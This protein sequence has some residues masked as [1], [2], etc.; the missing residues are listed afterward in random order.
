MKEKDKSATCLFFDVAVI[1]EPL[2]GVGEGFASRGLWEAEFAD[3]FGWVEEHFVGG[4]ADAGEGGLGRLAGEFGFGFV[5]VGGNEREGVGDAEFWGGNAGQFREDFEGFVHG[6]IAL[7]IA[8]YV[9]FAD[10]PFLG[11]EDVADG[12]IADVDPVEA[13]VE[14]GGH[15]AVEE[16]DDDAAGGGGFDVA[17]ADGS[18][19]IDDDDGGALGGEFAGN[20]FGAPLGELVVVAH[21]GFGNGSRFV[22]GC[23]LAVDF[24]GQTDAADGAGV[25]D[26]GTAGFGGG[27]DDVAGAVDVGGI[28]GS[29][30]AE[31]EMIAGGDVEAPVAAAHGEGVGRTV[32]DIAI[33]PFEVDALEA[34]KVAVGA[35]ESLHMVSSSD[36]F[37]DKIGTDEAGSACDEAVHISFNITKDSPNIFWE[38]TLNAVGLMEGIKICSQM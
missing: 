33:D 26:S 11:G 38:R 9:A 6:P 8:E 5:E 3:G 37:M 31:P 18:A 27:F 22:C 19:G 12:D 14:V 4:H 17:G 36:Q 25:D 35:E 23:D 34:A 20:D 32:A 30:V 29:V 13:G 7:G 16:V 21:L 10:S 24:P 15:F 2:D 28:H 1:A